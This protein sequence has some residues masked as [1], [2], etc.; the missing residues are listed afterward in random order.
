M[1]AQPSEQ[2]FGRLIHEHQGIIH[3][4][5]R[6]YGRTKAERED[7]F[8]EILIRVWKGLPA[9]RKEAKLST[10]LYRVALNTA[11]S[12]QRKWKRRI[13][14]DPL[15]KHPLP[16]PDTS[17]SEVEAAQVDALYR[18]IGQLKPVEK[19]VILLYLEEKSHQEIAEQQRR[20]W[21]FILIA[22]ILVLVGVLLFLFLLIY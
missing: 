4:V 14:F 15:P 11:I 16:S 21:R 9:F 6:V 12:E 8:Q 7:L 18:G 13:R 22:S 2:E 10:W 5:C 17:D 20:K 3:K 1:A 19:A